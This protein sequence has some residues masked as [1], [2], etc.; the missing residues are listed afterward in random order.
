MFRHLVFALT[1]GSITLAAPQQEA[2]QKEV[3]AP[4]WL[5]FRGNAL[6]TGVV[7]GKLPDKLEI[8]WQF[9]TGDAIE[10]AAAVADGVV[11]VGSQDEH[12]YAIDLANGKE[13]WK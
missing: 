9:K 11:F 2:A 10:G 8:L 3:A 13:K 1:L 6:Q 4:G 5:L 12:L 7:D